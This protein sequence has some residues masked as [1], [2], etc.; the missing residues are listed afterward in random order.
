MAKLKKL[1]GSA[2]IAGF[3]G[4]VDFYVYMGIP[5]ARAWPRKPTGARAPVVQEHWPAF[6]WAASNWLG[7]SQEVRDAYAHLAQDTTMTPRD[8]FT[9]SFING[10]TLYLEGE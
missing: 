6:S 3:K 9:K 8:V 4:V 2:I 5:C 7:L 10:D 1:P